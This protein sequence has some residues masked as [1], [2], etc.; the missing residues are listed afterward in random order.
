MPSFSPLP[1]F[2][3]RSLIGLPVKLGLLAK[4]P[5]GPAVG[6][7]T[8]SGSTGHQVVGN[9]RDGKEGPTGVPSELWYSV[10]V[11]LSVCLCALLRW[12]SVW[13]CEAMGSQSV[14]S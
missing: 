13:P 3:A 12:V 1:F 11:D 4:E 7:Q 2:E 5:W 14:G 8:A 9:E 10:Q 6:P